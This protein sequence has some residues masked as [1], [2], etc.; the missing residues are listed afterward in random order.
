VVAQI[1]THI[2]RRHARAFA[3]RGGPPAPMMV[4]PNFAS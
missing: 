1:L 2:M 4:H 3:A